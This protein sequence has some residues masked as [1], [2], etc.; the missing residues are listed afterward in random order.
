MHADAHSVFYGQQRLSDVVQW[1][2]LIFA[3]HGR[4]GLLKTRIAHRACFT[5]SLVPGSLFYCH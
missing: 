5:V 4:E 3:S 2:A 1:Y